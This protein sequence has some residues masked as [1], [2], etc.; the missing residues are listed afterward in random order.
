MKITSNKI[1]KE[2]TSK[3]KILKSLKNMSIMTLEQLDYQERRTRR[4]SWLW[5][6]WTVGQ[7]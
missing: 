2:N 4:T 7:Q 5:S 3:R 6:N 1:I